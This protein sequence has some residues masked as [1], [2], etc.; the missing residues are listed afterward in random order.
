MGMG[1]EAVSRMLHTLH[2]LLCIQWRDLLW[3]T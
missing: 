1:K 3:N 2:F